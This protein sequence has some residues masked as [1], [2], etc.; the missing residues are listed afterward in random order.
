MQERENRLF[1]TG[2]KHSGKTTFARRIALKLEYT[3]SDADDLILETTGGLTVRE[4]Y[5]KNGKEAFM[6][7]EREAVSSFIAH[8]SSPFVLSLGGGASDNT[9]LMEEMKESGIIVYLRRKEEDMLPIILRHGIP[10]FL[11]ANDPSSSFH[12][13]YS[14]RDRIY[15]E[16]ADLIIELGAYGDKDETEELILSSLKEAGYVR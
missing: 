1:F 7:K 6:D 8:T 10:A 4:Y 16:K 3:F 11:D 12:A 15:M 5:R 9:P 14:R 2:I 13:L